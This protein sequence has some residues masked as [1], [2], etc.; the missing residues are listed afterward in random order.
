MG[1]SA[2]MSSTYALALPWF[3]ATKKHQYARICV[4]FVW[5][6]L[7]AN[8]VI[9]SIFNQRRT[10]SL[11]GNTG[12]NIAW[13]Q[14]C[15]FLNLDLK[16]MNPKD[17][18]HI[19]RIL[20]MLNGIK[21]TDSRIRIALGVERDDPN[22]YTQVKANHVQAIVQCLRKMLGSSIEELFTD[23]EQQSRFGEGP[24]PWIKVRNPSHLVG[25]TSEE[26]QSEERQWVISQL[27]SNPFP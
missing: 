26:L 24:R 22:E 3:R 17:P 25:A 23:Q 27:E 8:P 4:D 5:V 19:D 6:L 13:D 10:C 2:K 14:A 16:N 21:C 20:L 18:R 15:E 7:T 11:L 12:Y 1:D 9:L